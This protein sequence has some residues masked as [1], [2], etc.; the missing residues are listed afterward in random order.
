MR[1]RSIRVIVPHG[2]RANDHD[3]ARSLRPS[4]SLSFPALSSTIRDGALPGV[5]VTVTQTGTGMTRFVVSGFG[6][7]IRL[8]EPAGRS[9]HFTA[10]LSGFTSFEQTGIVLAVGDSRS[11][12]VDDEDRRGRRDDHRLWPIASQVETRSTGVGARRAPGAD[13]RAAAEWPPGDATRG[14][15]R[16]RRWTRSNVA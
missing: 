3:R 13:R 8:H 12:N 4:P 15:S 6:R 5:E 14:C 10:K 16:A 2:D 1:C 7:R 9:L 11:L